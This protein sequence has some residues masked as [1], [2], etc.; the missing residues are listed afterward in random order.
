MLAE[1]EDTA[2]LAENLNP[3]TTNDGKTS[4]S[5]YSYDYVSLLLYNHC[6]ENTASAHLLSFPI[7]DFTI[8]P[9]NGS[10]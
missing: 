3:D 4:D 2:V 8:E 6:R 10:A 5:D 9:C 7:V 1:T